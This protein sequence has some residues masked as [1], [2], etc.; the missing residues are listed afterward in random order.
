VAQ[1]PVVSIVD[2]DV[3]VREALGG[4][5]NAFG[6]DAVEFSSGVEFLRSARLPDTS[7]LIVDVQMPEMNGLELQ[8]EL[9]AKRRPIPVI[10][11]TAFPDARIRALALE[12][13]AVGFLCKPLDSDDLLAHIRSALGRDTRAT[14]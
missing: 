5:V 6:F 4:L 11:V 9:V 10:F 12:T 2:D 1:R 7:C 13:G 14:S 8:A 3:S